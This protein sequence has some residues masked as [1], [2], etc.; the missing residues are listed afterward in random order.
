MLDVVVVGAGVAGLAATR[1]LVRA[2]FSVR[3]FEARERIGGRIF[4]LRDDA[5]PVAIELGAE[6]LHGEA[7]ETVEIARA[8]N[9]LISDIRGDRFALNHGRIRRLPEFWDRLGNILGR[10]DTS[11]PDESFADFLKRKPGGRKAAGDRALAKQFVEGFHAADPALV[12]A[13]SVAE[14]SPGSDPRSERQGR[15]PLGYHVIPEA[16]AEDLYDV[17]RVR[18]AVERIAWQR[19]RVNV[20]VRVARRSVEETA[21]AVIVTVPLGLLKAG[22]IDIEPA[23]P[24]FR[25]ALP[26]LHMGS[27]L[28]VSLLFREAF[29]EERDPMDAAFLHTS[30]KRFP[31]FWTALPNRAPLLVAW[32]GGPTA[33]QHANTTEDE[34]ARAAL[35]A[36]ATQFDISSRKMKG[37]FVRGVSHNWQADPFAR[38][39]Y[40]YTGVGGMNA[41][42]I[43]ATPTAQT[44]F[45]AGEA[46]AAGRNGTVDGAIA[47]G[48]RAARQVLKALS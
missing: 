46:S 26:L 5:C 45:I 3:L 2:G 9:F 42:K 29:W 4:T 38:G 30:D 7:P 12:S 13:Q 11:G 25:R 16:L 31:I 43:L 35:A 27:V 44:V 40:S 22:A 15:L 32:A 33:E 28:R 21:R 10:I 6:F 8:N 14:E 47:S 34:R 24:S 20:R 1:E 48:L 36:L 19:G 18:A 17:I 39:A 23:I 37:L 41:A